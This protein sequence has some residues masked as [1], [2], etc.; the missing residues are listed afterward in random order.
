[1]DQNSVLAK[2]S[3]TP[4]VY[5]TL[6]SQGQFYKDNP[7]AKSGTGEIPIYSMT[8]KDELIF[9]TPD[10]LM[11][12]DAV[13]T[14]IKS[15]VPLITDPWDIPSI[16]MDAI[17]VAIRIATTGEMLKL[18]T[19]V[20]RTEEVLEFEVNLAGVL[21]GI[22]SKTW[23]NTYSIGDLTF[24]VMPLKLRDQNF[25]E[26]EQFETQRFI[27]ILR[28]D[29]LSVEERKKQ[30]QI[31]L[32]KASDNNIE[33]IAKQ[34]LNITTPEGEEINPATIRQFLENADR[35]IYGELRKF[36]VENRSQFDIP[37]Q[38]VSVPEHMRTE[39]KDIPATV[40]VPVF[41]NNVNFF[42]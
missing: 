16:D 8:A 19:P 20:P 33:I 21:D 39:N 38:T 2:Y 18:E 17:L 24:T 25:F 13:A 6:P 12:G 26:I 14:V 9:R 27:K 32:N 36:L 5:L 23:S 30:A 29:S 4:K 15:C 37:N 31:V 22:K 35:K 3:R 7:C 10:A 1:M 42:V 40:D 28:D 41:L 34:I 11:N